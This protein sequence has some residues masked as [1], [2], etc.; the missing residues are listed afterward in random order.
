MEGIMPEEQ[1]DQV[2]AILEM[3]ERNEAR[4]NITYGG[5]NGDLA[6]P[7]SYDAADGDIFQWAAEAVRTGG[8]PGIPADANVD[9]SDFVI[10]R[11]DARDDQPS[12]VLIRP[13]TPFGA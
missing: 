6:D 9:F 7:V 1:N 13:K 12:K 8:V 2:D 11:F 10:D 4:L 5:F 3:V